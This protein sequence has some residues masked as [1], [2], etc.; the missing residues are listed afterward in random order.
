MQEARETQSTAKKNFFTRLM[1]E[2][3]KDREV[4]L[5]MVRVVAELDCLVSLAKA[6]HDM[7]EP[8]CRPEFVESEQ[9]LIDFADLRHPS[10]CLHRDFIAN[11]V[12][13]GGEVAR[14]T[15]L[16]G[17][18]MAGKSTLLRMTAAG[19]IMAQLGCYVPASRAK[20]SPIDKIQTRMGAY[21]SKL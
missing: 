13:L 7:D 10:M 2:F 8:K 6:S 16:T 19:V 15:L 20:L 1:A 12:Q 21:D 18:N 9:A 14:T 3:D 4:W 11:N 5:R 17:P